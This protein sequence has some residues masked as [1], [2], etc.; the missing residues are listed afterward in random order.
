MSSRTIIADNGGGITLQVWDGDLCVYQ[1][2]YDDPAT[3]AHDWCAA[4]EG[5]GIDWEGDERG[6]NGVLEPTRNEIDNG[7]YRVYDEYGLRKAVED[8]DA[9]TGWANVDAFVAAARQTY[10]TVLECDHDEGTI[11]LR[12]LKADTA[13]GD[14][15]PGHPCLYSDDDIREW[16]NGNWAAPDTD[17]RY[18][19]T[20]YD[21]YAIIRTGAEWDVEIEGSHE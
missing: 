12:S 14:I 9:D 21:E 7:G 2:Y 1:H 16:A 20:N 10:L 17:E 13:S 18:S 19:D 5:V 11:T 3:A 6:E 8:V 15:L 4:A